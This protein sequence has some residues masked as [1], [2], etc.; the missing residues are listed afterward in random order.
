MPQYFWLLHLV[1]FYKGDIVLRP[2]SK[3]KTF[4]KY[5]VNVNNN[6][7]E[8]PSSLSIDKLVKVDQIL[9]DNY[10]NKK[11]ALPKLIKDLYALSKT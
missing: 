8:M 10:L 6:F 5:K 11:I 2:F 1:K 9:I 4:L 3:L 7:S